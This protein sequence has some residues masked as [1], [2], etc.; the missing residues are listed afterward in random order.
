MVVHVGDEQ[1]SVGLEVQT[2]RAADRRLRGRSAVTAEAADPA[3]CEDGD[4]AARGPT[5]HPVQVA[6]CD[7]G[8]AVRADDE[9]RDLRRPVA[10]GLALG[11]DASHDARRR[12]GR[13]PRPVAQV[14]PPR[15]RVVGVVV[16][17]RPPA[18]ILLAHL[19]SAD[20]GR[21]DPRDLLI[22]ALLGHA[23]DAVPERD[24][25]VGVRVDVVR[26][27]RRRR[28]PDAVSGRL[29]SL[30]LRGGR[31]GERVEAALVLAVGEL[32]GDARGVEEVVAV[33]HLHAHRL[34]AEHLA[35]KPVLAVPD[36]AVLLTGLGGRER[37]RQHLS[38]DLRADDDR[39]EVGMGRTVTGDLEAQGP[40]S[41][42]PGQAV[43]LV[44]QSQPRALDR[45][46]LTQRLVLAPDDRP[47]RGAPAVGLP[48]ERRA[49][50]ACRARR[51]TQ[52]GGRQYDLRAGR[53]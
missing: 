33:E 50:G 18:E 45:H 39:L 49:G 19:G 9:P 36:E 13:P 27:R 7:V 17:Q 52:W 34:G 46:G 29:G 3:P 43:A 5:Q 12:G 25:G 24:A 20:G 11:H 47:G 30:V 42:V 44:M 6:L 1:A 38:R 22:G 8:A 40:C 14:Q 32:V 23:A 26:A 4:L 51:P 35:S 37:L 28:R 21:E 41:A 10:R 31:R 15:H 16:A 2:G 48:G 53:F